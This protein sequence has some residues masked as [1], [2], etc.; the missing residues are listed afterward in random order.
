MNV[1]MRTIHDQIETALY[2]GVVMKIR[3]RNQH[4]SVDVIELISSSLPVS[5]IFNTSISPRVIL[6]TISHKR[7]DD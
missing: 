4:L 7:S 2:R 3:E 6:H 1:T 5:D